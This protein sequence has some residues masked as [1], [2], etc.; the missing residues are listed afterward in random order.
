[1]LCSGGRTPRLCPPALA[2]FAALC[3][4][5]PRLET[6]T[7][8]NS[9]AAVQGKVRR[10]SRRGG[11]FVARFAVP[12]RNHASHATLYHRRRRL[13]GDEGG[14]S[15]KA[16][17]STWQEIASR[18]LATRDRDLLMA[19]W[20]I[21]SGQEGKQPAVSQGA[22]LSTSVR[23][24]MVRRPPVRFRLDIDP[25]VCPDAARVMCW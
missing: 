12:S 10:R 19:C 25:A 6:T 8:G 20:P 9:C 17:T 11:T 14:D 21:V 2:A 22:Q 5:L 3:A 23:Q 24:T 4:L 15:N 13:R 16:G 1:M 7:A 18:N